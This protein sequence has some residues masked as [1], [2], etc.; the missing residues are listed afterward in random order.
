[1]RR[2][3]VDAL[4][5][6][7]RALSA[8]LFGGTRMAHLGRCTRGLAQLLPKDGGLRRPARVGVGVLLTLGLGVF[9]R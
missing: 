1:M 2:L 7:V 5:I 4:A 9:T 6:S 8:K 3:L